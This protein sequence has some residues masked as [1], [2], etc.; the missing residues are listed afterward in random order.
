MTRS[1]L[2][3][4]R[5]V[6]AWLDEGSTD[7]S[8]RVLDAILSGIPATSQDRPHWSPPRLQMSSFAAGA[9]AAAAAMAVVVGASL[10]GGIGPA[11]PPA[12]P[13]ASPD[14]E[15]SSDP[16]ADR[17][18]FV[19]LP[20]LGATPTDPTPTELIESFFLPTG[21][22]P[23]LEGTGYAAYIGG[24]FLYADGRLIWNDY[25]ST[26]YT[27]WLEQRLSSV[28]VVLAL[29]QA[30]PGRV[31][32]ESFTGT[33]WETPRWETP[34]FLD[35]RVLP[36]LLPDRAWVD[37]TVRPYV[38]NGFAAC[39]YVSERTGPTYL[40][41]TTLT[42]ADKAAMLPEAAQDVLRAKAIVPMASGDPPA[43]CL[44]V[45]TAEARQ[46]DTAFRNAGFQ[47]DAVRNRG[48]LEY[49]V[50]V[51]RDEPGTWWL[52]IRFEPLLPDGTWMC[53]T[54]G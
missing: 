32:E 4:T 44:G 19:G 30:A 21:P 16:L 52:S 1:D 23:G 3:R 17:V 10:L 42:V 38:P 43:D 15:P 41:D 49:H 45:S 20:P 40:D 26:E 22:P 2:D 12:T 24:A 39:L 50:E 8:P 27:G 29:E 9:A 54:C 37:A 28:G 7:L 13:L 14:S 5:L 6:R 46:L 47:Q 51:D 11:G 53:S 25:T 31:I 18:G 48:T 35:P 33:V 36:V 34:R